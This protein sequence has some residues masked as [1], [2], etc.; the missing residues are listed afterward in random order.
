M[1]EL[2]KNKQFMFLFIIFII[3]SFVHILY[4][5]L[6]MRGMYEDGGFYMI[7]M[8]N[9]I[10]NNIFR[11]SYDNGHPRFFISIL[12]QLPVFVSGIILG[13][14]NKYV[15]MGIYSFSQFF[16]PF[17]ALLWNFKLTQRTKRYDI[18]FWSIFC[19]GAILMPFMIFS[20]VEILIGGMFHFILWNYLVSEID[21]KKRD[22]VAIIF[23]LI[24]MFTT[25][26]YVVALGFIF[27]LAHFN[28]VIN[29]KSI[30]N[31]CVKTLI[32]LGALGASIFN[33]WYMLHV[34][35]E[36]GEIMRFLKEAHDYMPYILNLNSLFSVLTILIIFL[37][38]FKKTKFSNLSL[39][40]IFFVFIFAMVYL[41]KHPTQ[42]VYPMWEQHFRTIPCWFFPLLFIGLYIKD[43]ISDK[44]HTIKYINFICVALI[45]CIFQNCWQLVDTYY[46]NKNIEYMKQ[47]LDKTDALLYIPSE[48]EEISGFHNEQLRRYIWHG[49]YAATSIL[50]SD[51]YEQRTL[52]MN[53]D[54]N[55]D[56]GNGTF[57]NFLYVTPW[58]PSVMSMPFGTYISVKNK[59]WDLTDCAAALDKYNK[60]NNI[61]TN[62]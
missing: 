13:I 26:E 35:G 19:Y 7:E 25:Y 20:V 9:N 60:E 44:F 37:L 11:F 55:Q 8:L 16:I 30:K 10:S 51:T 54:E 27:F 32:G 17:L 5:T 31:Q 39:G 14:K 57:R 1:E 34:P 4:A 6:S 29:E 2:R 46:W 48:H 59:F 58:N 52:L 49:I 42:S 3:I 12:H 28:Y 43:F 15:L 50:F 22:I 45:C 33:I 23:L 53:Y 38:F 24:I 61:E 47:E 21:Y 56:P 18:L 40:L 36:G 62:E 41:L